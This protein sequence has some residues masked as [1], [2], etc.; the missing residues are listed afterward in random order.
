MM[1]HDPSE[2]Y[3]IKK[4]AY[5][6]IKLRIYLLMLIS[7]ACGFILSGILIKIGVITV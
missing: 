4:A 5:D 3:G 7:F 6:E 2:L 1:A